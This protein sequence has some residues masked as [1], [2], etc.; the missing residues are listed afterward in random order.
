MQK[1][2]NVLYKHDKHS[3][4][5][6]GNRWGNVFNLHKLHGLLSQDLSMLLP[7]LKIKY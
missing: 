2:D 3:F 6:H 1:V 7:F 4:M 5:V